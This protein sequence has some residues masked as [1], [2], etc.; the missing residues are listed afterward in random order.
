MMAATIPSKP[1]ALPHVATFSSVDVEKVVALEPDLVV[2]GGLGF[3]PAESITKLRDLKVPV[4]VIYAP[5][6]EGV[7]KDIE[8]LGT[9]TGTS[10]AAESLTDRDAR[11]YGCG[12]I[13]GR[14]PVA[15]AEGVLRGR[16]RRHD[17]RDLRPGR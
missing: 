6:V 16:I 12:R 4:V 3:T 14:E 17:R 1:T 10:A 15:Q 2:A 9:A 7:L 8:L 11:G 13:G 5:S